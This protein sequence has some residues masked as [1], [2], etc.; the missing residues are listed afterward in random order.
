M[1]AINIEKISYFYLC[2]EASKVFKNIKD[3][4]KSFIRESFDSKV[5]IVIC[6]GYFK[7]FENTFLGDVYFEKVKF[8]KEL[9][10][11]NCSYPNNVVFVNLL[12]NKKQY[13]KRRVVILHCIGHDY[14]ILCSNFDGSYENYE[15]CLTQSFFCR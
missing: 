12:K 15:R 11:G 10:S 5:F 1:N 7:Y 4:S 13:I 9:K 2:N 8:K 6:Q 3:A 14:I